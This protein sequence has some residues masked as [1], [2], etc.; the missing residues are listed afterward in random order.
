MLQG[1]Q[2]PSLRHTL[3]LVHTTSLN[4]KTRSVTNSLT[5]LEINTS[6][7]PALAATRAAICIARPTT[8]PPICSYSP[9]CNPALTS[10]PRVRTAFADSHGAHNRSFRS[11]ESGKYSVA[12]SDYLCPAPRAQLSANRGVVVIHHFRPASVAQSSGFLSR[13]DDIDRQNRGQCKFRWSFSVYGAPD[14]QAV[15]QPF[16]NMAKPA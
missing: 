16:V 5:L 10:K 15:R 3:K 13:A 14:R 7:G 11:V 8:S 9:T 6:L 2:A 12:C 4:A 1:I